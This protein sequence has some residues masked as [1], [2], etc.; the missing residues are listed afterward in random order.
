MTSA[1]YSLTTGII[2]PTISP[3]LTNADQI[4]ALK[5]SGIGVLEVSD[6]IN[7]SNS[8]VDLSTGTIISLTPA[9]PTPS[10]QDQFIAACINNNV[11]P[12]SSFHANSIADLNVTLTAANMTGINSISSP[13]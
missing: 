12:A 2:A 11:V 6:G 5:A 13:S 9:P 10:L 4:A 8:I 3:S 7:A 1:L